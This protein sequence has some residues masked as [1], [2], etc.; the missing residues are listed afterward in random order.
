MKRL[1]MPPVQM[2]DVIA[3]LTIKD[4][5]LTAGPLELV[6]WIGDDRK[7]DSGRDLDGSSRRGRDCHQES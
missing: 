5:I 3:V 6:S 2:D 7:G 1:S 4:G